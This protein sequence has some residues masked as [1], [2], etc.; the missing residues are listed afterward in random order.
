MGPEPSPPWGFV[1][2]LPP[3]D[4][5]MWANGV[6]GLSEALFAELRQAHVRVCL[7]VLGLTRSDYGRALNSALGGAIAPELGLHEEEWLDPAEVARTAAFATDSASVSGTVHEVCMQPRRMMER[8]RVFNDEP[9]VAAMV[10]ALALPEF[11]DARVA[12]VTGCGKGIGRGVAVELCRAGYALAALTRTASDLDSLEREVAPFGT[13]VLKIAV[14]VTDEAALEAAV[15]LAVRTFGTLSC[16]VSNAGTNRRRVAALADMKN[17]REVVEV[18][19]LSAMNLTRLCLPYLLRHAKLTSP[20]SGRKPSLVFVSTGY[21]HPKGIAMNGLASYV[22]SK[23][24]TNAFAAVV[25]QEVRDLG[26]QVTAF[27]PGTV[28]T[29]LGL[30]PNAAAKGGEL[31][32]P[33]MLLH[34]SCCGRAVVHVCETSPSCVIQEICAWFVVCWSVVLGS[35]VLAGVESSRGE[36]VSRISEGEADGRKVLVEWGQAVRRSTL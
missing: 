2:T 7:L 8:N 22:T 15:G 21:A 30:K 28:A 14:D 4:H 24:G 10:A 33:V 29:D 25:A 13:H 19:L 20:H 34:P 9:R 12:L 11:R 3:A 23:R 31:I 26:V 18:D 5:V 16:V 27:N 1:L 35:D 32:D 36:L 6:L 17:W